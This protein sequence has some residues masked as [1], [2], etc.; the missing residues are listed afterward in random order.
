MTL[1]WKKGAC[2]FNDGSKTLERQDRQAPYKGDTSGTTCSV[3]MH[4]HSHS[5]WV[6]SLSVGFCVM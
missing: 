5:A 1:K 3:R 2:S 6:T 4:R